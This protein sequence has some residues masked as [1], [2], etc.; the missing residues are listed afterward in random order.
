MRGGT[1]FLEIFLRTRLFWSSGVGA[2]GEDP[3][4]VYADVVKPLQ[5]GTRLL[6]IVCSEAK[7]GRNLTLTAKV[8]SC[9]LLC[10]GTLQSPTYLSNCLAP[11]QW[12]TCM[13]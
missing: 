13:R 2:G 9:S 3:V 10:I 7:A 1:R 11:T 12:Q 8:M 5:R 6:Q 4:T